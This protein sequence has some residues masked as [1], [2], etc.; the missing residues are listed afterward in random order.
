MFHAKIVPY[1]KLHP[2]GSGPGLFSGNVNKLGKGEGFNE[3]IMRY[4]ISNIGTATY[5]TAKQLN[6]LLAPF[7][8]S[9][10]R[11]IYKPLKG[12]RISDS[13]QIISFDDKSLFTNVTLNE[14]I[15]IIL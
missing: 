14:T 2:T 11:N 12:Q 8:K 4:I 9:E 15:D 1:K 5:E 3:L 7:R 13:C 10:H 6:S